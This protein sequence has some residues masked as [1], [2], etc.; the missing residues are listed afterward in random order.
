MKNIFIA[1]DHA[2]YNLKKYIISKL[3]KKNKILD[4]GPK[5]NHSVDYPDFAKKLSNHLAQRGF[6]YDISNKIVELLCREIY[7]PGER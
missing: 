6:N 7:S 1:S 2:G 5:S 4:L 3:S